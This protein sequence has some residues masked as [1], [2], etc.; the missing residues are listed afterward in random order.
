METDDFGNT[1]HNANG[2]LLQLPLSDP[3]NPALVHAYEDETLDVYMKDV[4]FDSKGRPIV[5]FLTSLGNESGP[6]N[7][8]RIWRTAHWTGRRWEIRDAMISDNDY[9]TGSLYIESDSLW[10]LIAPTQPGPQKYN[11]GG[12]MAIWT[13]TDQG[14]TWEMVKQLT[15]NSQYNHTYCRRPDNAAPDFYAL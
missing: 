2:D 13:S 8:P 12:E 6:K 10:R 7:D 15:H 3:R 14:A 9:D 11:T 4:V 1:W 5:L